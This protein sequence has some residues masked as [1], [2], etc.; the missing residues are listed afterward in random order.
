M[1]V[2]KLEKATDISKK[3]IELK[4]IL[5]DVSYKKQVTISTQFG[6]LT[7]K[8]EELSGFVEMLKKK[9]AELEKE[10]AEL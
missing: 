2:E 6:K 1:T 7:I 8:T 10:F 9:K 5:C 3:L 4:Q